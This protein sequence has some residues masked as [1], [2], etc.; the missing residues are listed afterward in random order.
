MR[1][2]VASGKGGTGKTLVSTNLSAA[3]RSWLV[4]LD[5]EA[6]NC[7]LFPF[8][9]QETVQS[10]HRPVPYVSQEDCSSC[11]KCASFCRFGAV[12][13]IKG[14]VK[15]REEACHS[16]G[17]C[18]DL[19]PRKAILMRERKIGELVYLAGIHRSLVY[20]LMRIGEP[21]TVPLIRAVKERIPENVN[22]VLDCPPGVGCGVTEALSG[23]DV[24]LLVTEPTPF[25]MHDLGL[26]IKLVR[27]MGIPALLLL[28]KVGL[29]DKDASEYLEYLDKFDL[30][31]AASLPFSRFIAEKYSK[32]ELLIEEPRWKELFSR[33]WEKCLEVADK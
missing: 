26:A 22:A 4:D 20:G 18:M 14:Q 29:R 17:A 28:N 24:C 2:A 8:S 10:I 30:E 7:H 6:P 11:G 9:G 13:H 31:I 5:V 3:A 33:L 23:A 16:C 25:G 32:G 21:S 15:F 1:I 27:K 12:M 19:C